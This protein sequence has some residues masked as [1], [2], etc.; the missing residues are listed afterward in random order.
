MD[1]PIV[2]HVSGRQT[3][4]NVENMDVKRTI[5]KAAAAAAIVAA[6]VGGTAIPASAESAGGGTWN[7]GVQGLQAYNY[8]NYHH[9]SYY[10]RATAWDD[11]GKTRARGEAGQ[12]ANA[13]RKAAAWGNKASWYH[14]NGARDL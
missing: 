13:W 3:E 9:P 7:Y 14:N 5:G 10:H 4:E 12:W 6:L 8:S 11:A 1:H 2:S